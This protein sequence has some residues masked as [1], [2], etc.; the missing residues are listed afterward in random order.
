MFQ[1]TLKCGN[2]KE[3]QYYEHNLHKDFTAFNKVNFKQT[4]L[5][6]AV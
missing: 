5:E 3:N 1:Q 2:K 6:Q 4:F